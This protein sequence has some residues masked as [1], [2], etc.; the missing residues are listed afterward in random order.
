ME[1]THSWDWTTEDED[2]KSK[3][4]EEGEINENTDYGKRLGKI[5]K[6]TTLKLKIIKILSKIMTSTIGRCV[7]LSWKPLYK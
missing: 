7:P 4:G 2:I 5:L 6:N 1:K 3:V